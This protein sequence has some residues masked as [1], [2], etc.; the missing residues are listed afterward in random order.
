MAP[1]EQPSSKEKGEEIVPVNVRTVRPYEGEIVVSG[2]SGR[3]PDSANVGELQY[4]LLN[5]INMITVDN[6]RWEPGY[7]GTPD[8]MGKLKNITDFDAEFFG[9]HSKSANTMDPMLRILLEVVYEAIVDAGESLASLK[10]TRTG[11]YIGVSVAEF[12]GVVLRKFTSDD[13]YMI[14]GCAHSMF[15][16]WISYFFDIRGKLAR[17]NARNSFIHGYSLMTTKLLALRVE[18]SYVEVLFLFSFRCVQL[19]S[20]L[21]IVGGAVVNECAL[22]SAGTLLSWIRAPP[23]TSWPD[24]WSKSLRSPCCGLDI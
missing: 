14:Q 22:K 23:P 18:E 1:E 3:Y 16:N 19:F 20:F 12:E 7:A 24:G 6:R 5:G 4:N 9:V 13:C 21:G 8:V 15:A 10:G 11:V 17:P 2:I